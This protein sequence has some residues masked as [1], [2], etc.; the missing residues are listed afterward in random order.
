MS[1]LEPQDNNGPQMYTIQPLTGMQL[2]G[3]AVAL[4]ALGAGILLSGFINLSAF[5]WRI[6]FVILA[7]CL[8]FGLAALNL[9][10]TF[11]LAQLRVENSDK[12][13]TQVPMKACWNWLLANVSLFTVAMLLCW[14]SLRAK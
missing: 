6:I 1:T 3:V 10:A 9:R 11:R 13:P 12:L 14:L 2:T 4:G 7:A 8:C 5:G